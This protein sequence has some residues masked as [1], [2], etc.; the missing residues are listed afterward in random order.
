MPDQRLFRMALE[1]SA[2]TTARCL[3]LLSPLILFCDHEP[4]C[5]WR[6]PEWC[7]DWHTG[8][9]G[10]VPAIH[11]NSERRARW[12]VSSRCSKS[13]AVVHDHGVYFLMSSSWYAYHCA[14]VVQWWYGGQSHCVNIWIILGIVCISLLAGSV[15][16]AR[17]VGLA[18]R[19]IAA[20]AGKSVS[21]LASFAHTWCRAHKTLQSIV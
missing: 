16:L 14:G 15:G 6:H 12:T 1:N 17:Y 2:L 7:F 9:E 8:Y 19:E 13:W 3:L 20:F 10:G 11:Q 21:A 5:T 18:R 4:A